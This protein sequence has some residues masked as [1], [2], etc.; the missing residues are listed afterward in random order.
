MSDFLK[1]IEEKENWQGFTDFYNS[2]LEPFIE[3]LRIQ[4]VKKEKRGWLVA[5]IIMFLSLIPFSISIGNRFF[6]LA[7]KPEAAWGF[8]GFLVIGIGFFWGVFTSNSVGVETDDDVLLKLTDFR[9][10]THQ[11]HKSENLSSE[12]TGNNAL[13]YNVAYGSMKRGS[14]A[15][16]NLSSL[17]YTSGNKI[18]FRDERVSGF[19]QE[20]T[21]EGQPITTTNDD[22]T[23]SYRTSFEGVLIIAEPVEMSPTFKGRACLKETNFVGIPVERSLE[24]RGCNETAMMS[25]EFAE[26]FTAAVSSKGEGSSVLN[27]EMQERLLN[28]L[29]SVRKE[30][31]RSSDP[32]I[33]IELQN[34]RLKIAVELGNRFFK[35]NVLQSNDNVEALVRRL[36]VVQNFFESFK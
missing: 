22:S 5:K 12:F 13:L 10:I 18:E 23:Q 35:A 19:I 4:K 2:Q 1:N 30:L 32:E 27:N 21:I 26:K 6:D 25:Q 36:D 28:F 24:A 16:K 31:K 20:V 3:Q 7:L 14:A 11:Q 8:V 29:E 17:R 15:G 34:G 33:Y 9:G